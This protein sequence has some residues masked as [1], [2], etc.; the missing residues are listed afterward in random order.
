MNT[1]GKGRAWKS[2]AVN[3]AA[4][5][6]LVVSMVFMISRAGVIHSKGGV[7]LV[8][9]HGGIDVNTNGTTGVSRP[10]NTPA[11][12]TV[13]TTDYPAGNCIHCHD[14]HSSLDGGTHA[15][16]DYMLF[17][18]GTGNKN[19][20]C[21]TCHS[22]TMPTGGSYQYRIWMGSGI[23]DAS[24]HGT[25]ANVL[26]PGA[27]P[28][29]R[30]AG[31]Q[32]KCVNCHEQHGRSFAN[33]TE[34]IPVGSQGSGAPTNYV[35]TSPLPSMT[36]RLEENLCLTCHDGAPGKNVNASLGRGVNTGATGVY[37]N[38]PITRYNAAGDRTPSIHRVI[39]A[40]GF[41]AAADRHSECEDC[42]NPHY[43]TAG[44]HTDGSNLLANVLLGTW[45]IVNSAAWPNDQ[46]F[47][48]GTLYGAPGWN[49]VQLTNT[50]AQYEWQLC[51]RCHS[52]YSALP[53][54]AAPNNVTNIAREINTNNAGYHP[55]LGLGRHSAS[56]NV[57][58]QK[59]F[60]A[61]FAHNKPVTCSDCHE[62]NL[63][64]GNGMAGATDPQGPHGSANK[65][66]LGNFCDAAAGA[67]CGDP[68][69]T[70]ICFKCHRWAIYYTNASA[71]CAGNTGCS[72]FPDHTTKAKHRDMFNPSGIWCL[73][74]HAFGT[75]GGIHGS[76][77]A[78]GV[79]GTGFLG[80]N[81]MQGA[82]FGGIT[83]GTGGVGNSGICWSKAGVDVYNT[84]TGGSCTQHPTSGGGQNFTPNYDY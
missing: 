48:N 9:E 22:G 66:L 63:T 64:T 12:Y 81:L 65:W 46:A 36:F 83:R 58:Y 34:A 57:N 1:T 44:L 8:T 51:L 50:A 43:A 40:L 27:N 38:H 59:S 37:Y 80:E 26:W 29:A 62:S 55:I 16:E 72:R 67:N 68:Q 54:Y 52:N 84:G 77:A 53:A 19:R 76:N 11:G 56:A 3:I 60:R 10:G 17:D 28:A 5:L 49:A 71:G 23:F 78:K 15:V 7:Y 61:P 39:E 41:A 14:E 2:V 69:Q 74:C 13:N 20:V 82:S 4:G 42:H 47:G 35:T 30:A 21:Y 18:T 75:E 31:E 6:A 24:A 73:N 25:N 70:V 45:G 33:A 32:N 79:K